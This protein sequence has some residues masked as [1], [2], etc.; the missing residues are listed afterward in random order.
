[1]ALWPTASGSFLFLFCQRAESRSIQASMIGLIGATG[2]SI[3]MN[4]ILGKVERVQ[5]DSAA[6]AG[7]YKTAIE[8]WKPGREGQELL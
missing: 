4:L 6:Y 1:M 8:Q 5:I 7:N 2:P 3:N